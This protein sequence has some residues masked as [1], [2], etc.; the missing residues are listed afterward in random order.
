[1]HRYLTYAGVFVTLVLIQIFLIDNISL[2]IYFHPLIYIAFLIVLP[3]DTK[4]VWVVLLAALLGLTI[5]TMT[6]LGGL[7]VIAATATG[8]MRGTLLGI[9]SGHS[10]STD[11][12]IPSLY[13][14]TDKNLAWFIALVILF[15]SSI[16]FL[17]E[18]LSLHHLLRTLLRI[19]LSSAGAGAFVWLFVKLFIEKIFN[20]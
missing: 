18:S 2:G 20:K 13:R 1:M 8:F 16:Y 11:D 12:S 9:T 17:L 7:N 6:G 5:D 15:H 10:T 3:L 14:L 19:I 4:P